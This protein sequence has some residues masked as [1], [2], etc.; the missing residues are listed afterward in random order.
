MTFEELFV[1]VEYFSIR[2]Q[3][4][5]GLLVGIHKILYGI[6]TNIYGDI[7]VRNN[8]NFGLRAILEI[9]IPLIN[10]DFKSKNSLHYHSS[11]SLNNLP[12]EM[13][14]FICVHSKN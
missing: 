6:L 2:N 8:H 1:K 3:N 10:S 11:V 12:Y 14:K 4:I 9:K 13:R 7:F 5:Q